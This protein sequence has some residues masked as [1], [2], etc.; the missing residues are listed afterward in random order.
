MTKSL[1]VKNASRKMYRVEIAHA[2]C[3]LPTSNAIFYCFPIHYRVSS[4]YRAFRNP[5]VY[6]LAA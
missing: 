3:F 2:V 6:T 4:G 1:D 5:S